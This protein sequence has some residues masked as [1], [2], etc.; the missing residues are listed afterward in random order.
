MFRLPLLT[1]ARP[2]RR[3]ALLNN[4]RYPLTWNTSGLFWTRNHSLGAAQNL[5]NVE[6]TEDFGQYSI[7]LPPEP[8][9]F[10]VSHIKPRHVP[11]DIVK[12]PYAQRSGNEPLEGV[13]KPE[14]I[15]KLGG[16][17]EVRMRNAARLAKSVREFA[18]TLVKVRF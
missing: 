6:E 13:D 12:P 7:I 16:E 3:P 18:G 10:G 9:V 15:I 17:A 2:A 4:S 14:S 5:D 11:E 8:F 1:C